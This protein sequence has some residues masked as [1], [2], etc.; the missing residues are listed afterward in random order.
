MPDFTG[1][2]RKEVAP[3]GDFF[4]PEDLPGAVGQAGSP[5]PSPATG[6]FGALVLDKI[7]G[8]R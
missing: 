4:C 8:G 1:E 7:R 5:G 3:G 6:F 2:R